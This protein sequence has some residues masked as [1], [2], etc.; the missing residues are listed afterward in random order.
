LNLEILVEDLGVRCA[1]YHSSLIILGYLYNALKQKQLLPVDWPALELALTAHKDSLFFGS[2][3]I[4]PKDSA[5]RLCLRLGLPLTAYLDL[6]PKYLKPP[7]PNQNM[8]KARTG[9]KAKGEVKSKLDPNCLHMTSTSQAI[10]K[11]LTGKDSMIR[12][13]HEIVGIATKEAAATAKSTSGKGGSAGKSNHAAKALGPIK[14]LSTLQQWLVRNRTN[15]RIDYIQ[16]TRH[17]H[18]L[19]EE[20]S[21]IIKPRMETDMAHLMS[22]RDRKIFEDARNNVPGAPTT[23]TVRY[24]DIV[25]KILVE[26]KERTEWRREI[27]FMEE[28]GMA[29]E[30]HLGRV[31]GIVGRFV[32][33]RVAEGARGG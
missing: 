29:E 18:T 22:T 9:G 24:L 32:E 11:Y 5:M 7:K 26:D 27:E 33:A 16:L 28:R 17:C 13:V 20:I 8:T 2:F 3:P 23:H 19:M 6:N 30:R 12:V 21:T 1:N 4:E 31:S 25:Q 10:E 14:F 15:A